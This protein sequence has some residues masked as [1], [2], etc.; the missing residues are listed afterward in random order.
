MN[1]YIDNTKQSAVKSIRNNKKVNFFQI[2]IP[3]NKV[4]CISIYEE[5]EFKYIFT[6]IYNMI[7]NSKYLEINLTNIYVNITEKIYGIKSRKLRNA[8]IIRV[9]KTKQDNTTPGMINKLSKGSEARSM[10][11]TK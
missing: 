4:N 1:V 3:Y 6:T 11:D 8:E 7:K 10:H 2:F 5:Q 9:V